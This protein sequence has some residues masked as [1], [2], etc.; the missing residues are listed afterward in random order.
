MKHLFILLCSVFFSLNLSAQ[1]A[2]GNSDSEND[3]F[4]EYF[5]VYIAHE[6]NDPVDI[7]SRR[8]KEMKD[9]ADQYGNSYI[10]YLS[11]ESCPIIVKYNLKGGN[12]Q[13]FNKLI[14]ELNNS[15]SHTVDLV[16]DLD[17][18][19]SLINRYD[20]IDEKGHLKYYSAV[21]D[22]FVGADFWTLG[23]NENLLAKLYFLLDVPALKKKN[24]E[25]LFRVNA[26]KGNYPHYT[27]GQPFGEK[28]LM[29]INNEIILQYAN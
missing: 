14:G 8:L 21:M 11:N 7:I 13:D 10:F 24:K 2:V 17:S 26:F 19:C 25:F 20:F 29:G 4:R 18:I 5:F 27:K 22:F 1:S 3:E 16:T 23:F 12:P 6:E 9:N 15:I 28:N